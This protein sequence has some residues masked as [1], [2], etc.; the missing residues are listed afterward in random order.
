MRVVNCNLAAVSYSRRAGVGL[1]ESASIV[2]EGRAT[3]LPSLDSREASKEDSSEDPRTADLQS[4]QDVNHRYALTTSRALAPSAAPWRNLKFQQP[5]YSWKWTALCDGT[6][7]VDL[8]MEVSLLDL[9][10]T[11][12]QHSDIDS[13]SFLEK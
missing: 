2:K 1:T 3:P 10:Q 7:I 5:N 12:L 9:H 4:A 11:T 13:S 6:R 8:G